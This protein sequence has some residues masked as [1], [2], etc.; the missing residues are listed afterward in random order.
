MSLLLVDC[1]VFSLQTSNGNI[2]GSINY[3]NCVARPT[4]TTA[5][6]MSSE[7]FVSSVLVINDVYR[8]KVV[9]D[10]ATATFVC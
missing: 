1:Q 6:L 7:K 4:T 5:T 9:V 8:V 2:Y 3:D 10:V